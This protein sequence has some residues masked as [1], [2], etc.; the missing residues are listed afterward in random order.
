MITKKGKQ[1]VSSGLRTG[2]LTLNQDLELND[3]SS[4]HLRRQISDA[5]FAINLHLSEVEKLL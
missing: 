1:A 2:A 3:Q 5:N 4:S